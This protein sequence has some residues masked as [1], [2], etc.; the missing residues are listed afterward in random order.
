M[1][2]KYRTDKTQHIIENHAPKWLVKYW[3]CRLKRMHVNAS[4]NNFII[5]PF[6]F[7]LGKFAQTQHFMPLL[8]ENHCSKGLEKIKMFFRLF[9]NSL[10]SDFSQISKHLLNVQHFYSL[11]IGVSRVGAVEYPP[12]G[13]DDCLQMMFFP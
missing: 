12:N 13:K 9:P 3:K 2:I 7:S 10:Y 1:C 8:S 6:Y 11:Y 5:S 4:C